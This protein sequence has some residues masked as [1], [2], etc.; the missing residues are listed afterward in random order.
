MIL[1]TKYIELLPLL[2]WKKLFKYKNIA[3]IQKT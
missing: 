2:D 3:E 1:E